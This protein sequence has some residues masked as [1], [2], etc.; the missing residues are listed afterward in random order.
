MERFKACE[1]EMKTK[2]YSREGLNAAA[3]ID[4]KEKEKGEMG[5]W[6]STVVD[7]LNTQVDAFEAKLESIQASSKKSKKG[8]SSDIERQKQ[9]DARI[10][11]HKD[12][13]SKLELALRLLENGVLQTEQIGAIKE[14]VEYYIENNEDGDFVDDE[15]I[16]DDLNLEEEGQIFVSDDHVA[17][18][19]AS[20]KMIKLD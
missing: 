15:F 17:L 13:M 10:L 6:I 11:K 12:H 2:A 14:D 8:N 7:R 9:L 16:Y 3:K 1:R 20:G 18:D 19:S 4:P 5:N